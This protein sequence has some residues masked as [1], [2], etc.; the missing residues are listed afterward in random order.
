[1]TAR[2]AFV[3]T[4]HIQIVVDIFSTLVASSVPELSKVM[5]LVPD[6]ASLSPVVDKPD[7]GGHIS[8][9]A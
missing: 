5:I 8:C 7:V 2:S 6:F 1:M 3:V 9:V 4:S